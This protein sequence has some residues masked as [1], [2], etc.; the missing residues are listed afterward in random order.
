MTKTLAV[1]GAGILAGAAL[2]WGVPA[3]S[4]D[5]GNDGDAKY[6][7]QVPMDEA[8]QAE[9]MKKWMATMQTGKYH[10]RLAYF[11]GDW[12]TTA[13]MS[14]GGPPEKIEGKATFRWLMDGRWLAQ[15]TDMPMMGMQMKGFG[16]SGYDNFK[17]QYVGMW[18]DSMGTAM[19]T[20]QGNIDRTGKVIVEYGTMDE[21]GLEQVG[22]MAKYVTRIVDSDTFV[23]EIHDLDIIGGE[24]KVMEITY[25]RKKTGDDG[26]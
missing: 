15:E 5:G 16:I 13:T 10:E 25:H 26:K 19:L 14:M 2:V 18:V 17:H 23:F 8:S 6:G 4:Q 1:F 20:M 9:M 24:T 22:K 12:S 3:F 21:P 7:R 11:L